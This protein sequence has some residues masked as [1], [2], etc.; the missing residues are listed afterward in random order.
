MRLFWIRFDL[1]EWTDYTDLFE[2]IWTN[3]THLINEWKLTSTQFSLYLIWFDFARY[4]VQNV[5]KNMTMI[6]SQ[7]LAIV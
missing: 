7:C 6:Q 2:L 5:M 3:H 1:T 4:Y